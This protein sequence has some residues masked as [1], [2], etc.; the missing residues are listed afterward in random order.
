MPVP[1]PEALAGYDKLGITAVL[2]FVILTGLVVIV[3]AVKQLRSVAREFIAFVREITQAL[4]EVQDAMDRQHEV[5]ARLHERLD[6]LVSCTRKGCPVYDMRRK[7]QRDA[8]REA[9]GSPVPAHAPTPAT[10]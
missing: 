5:A 6:G 8:A 10:S 2:I 7:Q 3:W 4:A 9:A 1:T